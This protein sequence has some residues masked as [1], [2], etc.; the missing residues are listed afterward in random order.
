MEAITS[1]DLQS[2]FLVGITGSTGFVG[3]RLIVYL[4]N[5]KIPF[6]SFNGDLLIK[7]DVEK[8]FKNN[9]V[10]HIIHL[11]GTFDLPF[12]NQIEKNAL[13]TQNILEVGRKYSLKKIIY[14][15]TGAV[16]G[17]S[18]RSYSKESDIINPNTLYG[19]TKS[20][21]EN[22]INF[23]KVNY[24]I[25]YIILR[26][27]SIYGEENTKGVIYNFL[28]DI[29][30]K[31]QIT[32]AGDGKQRRQFL[33]VD[34]ACQALISTLTYNSSEIFNISTKKSYSLN[35][36]IALLAK[37]HK[38]STRRVPEDNKL[39]NL[40]INSAKAKKLINFSPIGDVKSYLLRDLNSI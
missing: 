24:S 30:Y 9:Q 28:Y 33:Y 11:A 18:A 13:T 6:V 38:F 10:T 29:K 39:K 36:L 23:Y 3:K 19:L 26:F 5:K 27:S 31:K 21:A 12:Q 40:L 4:R 22:I 17:E 1:S 15:S 14:A 35:E 37:K 2:P 7:N 16:Y 32:I 8:F 34:D 25:D 20:I